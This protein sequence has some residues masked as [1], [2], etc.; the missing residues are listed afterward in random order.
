M[1]TKDEKHTGDSGVD[2]LESNAKLVV[3]ADEGKEPKAHLS[4]GIF[5]TIDYDAV[6]HIAKVAASPMASMATLEHVGAFS[7][8]WGKTLDEALHGIRAY[9]AK[10]GKS[11]FLHMLIDGLAMDGDRTPVWLLTENP[12]SEVYRRRYLKAVH[13][14]KSLAQRALLGTLF[15]REPEDVAKRLDVMTLAAEKGKLAANPKV[16]MA[17][18]QHGMR[19]ADISDV[20]KL[21]VLTPQSLVETLADQ[22]KK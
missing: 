3:Y 11:F 1:T 20:S 18:M 4:E 15:G 5:D 10:A 9:N 21:G 12:R 13:V 14:T 19:V 2:A 16:A 7:Q 17:K 8:G 6:A 22:I